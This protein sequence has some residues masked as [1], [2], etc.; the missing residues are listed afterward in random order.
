MNAKLLHSMVDIV[1]RKLNQ[2]SSGGTVVLKCKDFRI[3]SLEINGFN[4]LNNVSNS[5]EWLSN[6]DDPRLLYPYFYRAMFES[7][8]DGWTQF[9]IENE[10]SNILML[11]DEWRL[12]YVNKNFAVILLISLIIFTNYSFVQRSVPLIPRQ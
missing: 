5:I 12:T 11:T 1:E 7:V 9:Q 3:I 8:E 6:L 2:N 10:F 4:E